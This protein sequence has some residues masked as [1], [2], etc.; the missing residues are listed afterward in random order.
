MPKFQVVKNEVTHNTCNVKETIIKYI[1]AH[2][3]DNL[4]GIKEMINIK[5]KNFDRL[6]CL[7]SGDANITNLTFNT[8]TVA[9]WL[10]ALNKNA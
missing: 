1:F 4:E 6:T 8:A 10:R 5:S 7:Q 2:N 9:Q 3:K